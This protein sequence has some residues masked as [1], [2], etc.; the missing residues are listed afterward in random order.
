M[1]GNNGLISPNYGYTTT[2]SGMGTGALVW[3]IVSLVLALVGCFVVYFAFVKKKSTPK[4]KFLAWLKA[5]LDFDKMLIEP[6]L[7]I[8][9]IF[10]AIFITLYSFALIGTSFVSFLLLLIVGNIVVRLIYEASLMFVMLWKNT[11]EIK[12]RLK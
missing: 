5:F 1:L 4:E 2:G 3:L 11:T 6:I 8:C 9:Y 12:N 7:K 10:V